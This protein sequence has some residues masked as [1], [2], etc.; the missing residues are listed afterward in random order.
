MSRLKVLEQGV[1][2]H[3][4]E[5][6]LSTG[7]NRV[8]SHGFAI[9]RETYLSAGGFDD[10]NYGAFTPWAFGIVLAE[11]G[12][13]IGYAERSVVYHD[14]RGDWRALD[15]LI[16]DF[17]RGESA[18]MAKHS[19]ELCDRYLPD[20]EEWS[21]ARGLESGTRRR[22]GQALVAD[23]GWQM[24]H[25]R[26]PH[27]FHG[28]S[29]L[30]GLTKESL[31]P[32]AREAR[33]GV[34]RLFARALVELRRRDYR[35][36]PAFRRYCDAVAD[37]ARFSAL[38]RHGIRVRQA[39][40]PCLDFEADQLRLERVLGFH[41]LEQWDGYAFRW[42]APVAM[43]RPGLLT[44]SY[45][46]SIALLPGKRILS[47]TDVSIY[48]AGRR[49]V[50][51][52]DS[53]SEHLHFAFRVGPHEAGQALVLLSSPLPGSA[54]AGKNRALGLPV[55]S[56]RFSPLQEAGFRPNA[57]SLVSLD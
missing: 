52:P 12:H 25:G 54:R 6:G 26:I 32:P 20:R 2:E 11:A 29:A 1:F 48:Y 43:V 27:A 40:T 42:S 33:A 4:I 21:K 28:C 5:A 41:A 53:T 46:L 55:Q 38:R 45:V 13:T 22:L 16:E 34:R 24:G 39:E 15:F 44:G 8:L 10:V 51:A 9:T 7:W 30:F 56:I 47:P 18:F 50:P 23:I 3:D 17:V 49:L 31:K 14:Y 19:S 35:A 36:A 37:G 57:D